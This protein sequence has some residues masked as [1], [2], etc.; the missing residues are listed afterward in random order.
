MFRLI[1]DYART[2]VAPGGN[3]FAA[4]VRLRLEGLEAREVPAN[5][6]WDVSAVGSAVGT[7]STG[8]TL[9][10]QPGGFLTVVT[11]PT[12]VISNAI[13]LAGY[14]NPCF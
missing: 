12:K 3:Q 10:Y 2:T 14:T 4:V 9:L 5:L 7:V 11:G 13:A 8:T 1:A 6:L